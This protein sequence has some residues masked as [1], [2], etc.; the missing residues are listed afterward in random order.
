[1]ET[2]SDMKSSILSVTDID[3][4]SLDEEGGNHSIPG[5]REKTEVQ[6]KL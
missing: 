3:R 5:L 4:N 6:L 1:M 2:N